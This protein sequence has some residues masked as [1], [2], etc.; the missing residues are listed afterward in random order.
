MT[1]RTWFATCRKCQVV[2]SASRSA[3]TRSR[4]AA[5]STLDG[6][7]EVRV[8]QYDF[9]SELT[10]ELKK[11]LAKRVA[12]RNADEK[13]KVDEYQNSEIKELARFSDR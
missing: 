8:W 7:S 3:P 1:M 5:A 12:D 4:L 6:K 10:D 11:I 9:T 2:F 13:K